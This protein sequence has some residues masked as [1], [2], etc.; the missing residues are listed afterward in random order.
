MLIGRLGGQVGMYACPDLNT[1]ALD[2]V[3]KS[4]KAHIQ[5]LAQT[6]R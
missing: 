1:M 4:L 2:V 6:S 3:A 5:S